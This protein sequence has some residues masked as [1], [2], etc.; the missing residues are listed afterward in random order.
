MLA[1]PT[2]EKDGLLLVRQ[3]W[4]DPTKVEIKAVLPGW[5]KP[6]TIVDKNLVT[7]VKL[8]SP[9][10]QNLAEMFLGEGWAFDAPAATHL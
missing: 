3:F 4:R 9:E 8:L 6:N 2:D 7:I 1:H 10:D 5:D